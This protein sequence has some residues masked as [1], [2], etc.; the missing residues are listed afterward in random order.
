[1]PNIQQ[2]EL[3]DLFLQFNS[4]KRKKSNLRPLHLAGKGEMTQEQ[5]ESAEPPQQ[6]RRKYRITSEEMN[7]QTIWRIAPKEKAENDKKHVYYLHG[8]TYVDGFTNQ[9]WRFLAKLVDR[10]HWSVTAPDYPL[11][12]EHD[13]H[14]AFAMLI[15]LYRELVEMVDASKLTLMGDSAGGS[16]SIRRR[17]KN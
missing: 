13:V 16:E 3:V 9:H 5:K 8:G 1:M 12:P 14:D 2:T 7:E 6:M 15:P 10:F 17:W 4:A 11:A